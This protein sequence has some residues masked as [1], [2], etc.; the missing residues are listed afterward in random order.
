IKDANGNL[1]VDTGET[2]ATSANTGTTNETILKTGL[3]AGTYYVRVYESGT[4]SLNYQ[5][6]LKTDYAGNSLGLA[7]N[8]GTLSAATTLK[9]WVGSD[10]TDDF[11]KFTLASTKP[12]TANLTGLAADE[13][14]QLVQDKNANGIIDSGETIG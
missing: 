1:I 13:N 8:I 12:F 9:E 5:L 10:D 7:R 4:A 2:L 3:A 6:S 11:Y 14:L